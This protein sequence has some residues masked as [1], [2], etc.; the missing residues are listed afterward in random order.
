MS[1]CDDGLYGS[2]LMELYYNS[3]KSTRRFLLVNCAQVQRIRAI[4]EEMS[5]FRQKAVERAKG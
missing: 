2:N 4:Q 1:A 5:L 3:H